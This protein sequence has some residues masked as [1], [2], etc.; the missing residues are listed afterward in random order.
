LGDSSYS[1]Y[2]TH[3]LT[4]ASFFKVYSFLP[5]TFR[6]PLDVLIVGGVAFAALVAHMI[7]VFLER[8]MTRALNGVWRQMRRSRLS[9]PA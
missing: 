2:L 5:T 4:I 1:L 6:L 8:P 3:T 7:Y 9:Q